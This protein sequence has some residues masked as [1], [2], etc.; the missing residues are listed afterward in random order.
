MTKPIALALGALC[1]L[2][3]AGAAPTRAQ[4]TKFRQTGAWTV[5]TRFEK[6]A[7]NRCIANLQG[8][9]GGLRIAHAPN[10]A[11][12]L[13]FPGV[14]GGRKVIGAIRLNGLQVPR[15]PFNNG[16]GRAWT[17]LSVPS[18]MVPFRLILR[19]ARNAPV[20][21]DGAAPCFDRAS[22]CTTSCWKTAAG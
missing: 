6:G 11:W 20:S 2:I 7:F 19:R 5:I 15:L 14:P 21:K 12:S 13:S 22:C 1:F 18:P 4:E 10:G 17:P 9:S 16:G 3:A 8:R